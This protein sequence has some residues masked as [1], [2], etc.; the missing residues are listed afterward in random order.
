MYTGHSGGKQHGIKE[1]AHFL[2]TGIPAVSGELTPQ[3][4]LPPED[5]HPSPAASAG[6]SFLSK[7]GD[8]GPHLRPAPRSSRHTGCWARKDPA[9]LPNT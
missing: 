7:D 8:P 3:I 4:Q 9:H 6:L 5:P 1:R 2:P